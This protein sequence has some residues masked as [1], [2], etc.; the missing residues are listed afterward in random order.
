MTRDCVLCGAPFARSTT[1]WHY[2]SH[3][4]VHTAQADEGMQFVCVCGRECETW[5]RLQGHL[6]STSDIKRHRALFE[7]GVLIE[8]PING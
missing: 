7:L 1:G 8:V 5:R 3:L 4:R 6:S 2:S